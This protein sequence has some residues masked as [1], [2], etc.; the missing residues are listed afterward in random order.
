VTSIKPQDSKNWSQLIVFESEPWLG[1]QV[2]GESG[3]VT[4]IGDCSIHEL[5]TLIY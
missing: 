1:G 3:V 4:L 5:A 2:A